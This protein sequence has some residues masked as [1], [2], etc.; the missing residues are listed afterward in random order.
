MID[1]IELNEVQKKYVIHLIEHFKHDGDTITLEQ[2]KFYHA[3]M[4]Q[5]RSS[6]GP[7]F[8]YPNWLIKPENKSA[9]SVYYI[10]RP[11]EDDMD[12]FLAGNV[13]AQ[14]KLD[15]YSPML[16]KVVKDYGLL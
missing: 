8:G 2:M 13:D 6:G 1:F 16:Q 11:T 3:K 9:K 10:P 15:K 14:I 5:E 4:M 7:K 12:D